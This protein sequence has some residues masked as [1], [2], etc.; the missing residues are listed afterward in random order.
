MSFLG[1]VGSLM[2][3]S[4]LEELFETVYPPNTVSHMISGK[5]VSRAFRAHVMASS[6]LN[7]LLIEEAD[8]DGKFL[9]PLYEK[10]I[11]KNLT[12]EDIYK[13]SSTVEYKALMDAIERK[14]QE[15]EKSSRTAKLWLRYARYIEVAK[16]FVAAERTS[17]WQ[18]HL[19]SLDEMLNVFAATGHGNY[20]KCARL[21]LEEMRTLSQTHPLLHKEFMDGNHSVKRSAKCWRGLWT[22]LAIEQ[23]YM[24]DIKSAGGLT[25]GRGMQEST[26]LLWVLSLNSCAI[27]EKALRQLTSTASK[28]EFHTELRNS[29]M[30]R[31]SEDTETYLGWFRERN[32]FATK[33][34]NLVSL[35]SGLISV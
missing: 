12:K 30:K 18:L 22:D 3:S 28:G 29:R 8:V 26:R 23:M 25:R 7:T 31:D 34:E 20:A 9:K 15:L 21:Y 16:N 11:E 14:K 35:S 5:A 27:I 13:L 4:G 6:A 19:D 10:A 32:P 33:T 24:R 1:S 2:K 17:D